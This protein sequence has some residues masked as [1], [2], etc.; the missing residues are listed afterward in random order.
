M[1]AGEERKMS[2]FHLFRIGYPDEKEKWIACET[3][4]DSNSAISR[5]KEKIEKAEKK[6]SP[7]KSVVI[8]Y[9]GILELWKN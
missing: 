5:I 4:D 3:R 6:A 1:T 9:V 8:W 7:A 2:K